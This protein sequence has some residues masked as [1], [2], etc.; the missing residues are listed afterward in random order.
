MIVS[1]MVKSCG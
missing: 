1:A